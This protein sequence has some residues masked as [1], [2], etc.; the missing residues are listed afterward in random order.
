MQQATNTFL[1]AEASIMYFHNSETPPPPLSTAT[2]IKTAA[3]NKSKCSSTLPCG[4]T[5]TSQQQFS[6][7]NR[8]SNREP[9]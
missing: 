2:T 8:D 7:Q 5:A 6:G 4:R 3:K 9:N 1:L